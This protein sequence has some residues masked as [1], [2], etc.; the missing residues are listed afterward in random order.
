MKYPIKAQPQTLLENFNAGMD[1]RLLEFLPMPTSGI[2]LNLG[3]GSKE[4]PNTIPMDADRGWMAP[5]LSQFND[6]EVSGIYAYHF[7][8][9][10]D[11]VTLLAMLKECERVLC[12]GGIFNIVVPWWASEISHQD[13]DHKSFFTEQ[14]WENLFK[15]QYYDG[16]MPRDWH[17]GI[18]AVCL[19]GLVQRNM[20]VMTQLVRVE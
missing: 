4:I 8:E 3:A 6:G 11:K 13:L 10:L 12:I 5:S 19:M 2:I 1:R 17:F 9:H 20:V 15:N 7:L 14:T 18:Q 16:T